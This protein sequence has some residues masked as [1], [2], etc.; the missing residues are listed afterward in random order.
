M[1]TSFSPLWR[2]A[3][4]AA[5]AFVVVAA[6]TVAANTLYFRIGVCASLPF[7]DIHSGWMARTIETTNRLANTLCVGNGISR[8]LCV[9]LLLNLIHMAS[10]NNSFDGLWNVRMKCTH[11]HI[12]A[13]SRCRNASIFIS[14]S[15]RNE[16]ERYADAISC[17]LVNPD[18]DNDINDDAKARRKCGMPG[19]KTTKKMYYHCQTIWTHIDKIIKH[20]DDLKYQKFKYWITQCFRIQ[21]TLFVSFRFETK[22]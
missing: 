8:F 22:R 13:C 15:I 12:I 10:T 7:V 1:F 17:Y 18:D 19:W 16:M 4:A 20:A 21:L 11:K 3:T 2:L 5:S 6:N 14:R 9:C